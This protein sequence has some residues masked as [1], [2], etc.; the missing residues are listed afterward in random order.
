MFFALFTT[1][2]TTCTWEKMEV[3]Q[4]FS[5]LYMAMPS[6]ILSSFSLFVPFYVEW[7]F[8]SILLLLSPHSFINSENQMNESKIRPNDADENAWDHCC[9]WFD[10]I[11]WILH[12]IRSHLVITLPTMNSKHNFY[13]IEFRCKWVFRRLLPWATQQMVAMCDAHT[14]ES[15]NLNRM[16]SVDC[17]FFLWLMVKYENRNKRTAIHCMNAHTAHKCKRFYCNHNWS[18]FNFNEYLF[19]WYCFYLF[20]GSS[21]HNLWIYSYNTFEHT[22]DSSM[23]THTVHFIIFSVFISRGMLQQ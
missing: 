16:E 11:E 12:W 23:Y 19:I 13:S 7:V 5:W 8:F 21:A 4:W 6:K 9:R 2:F 17:R 3:H 18:V 10:T 14:V 22:F 15:V 20:F 1:R